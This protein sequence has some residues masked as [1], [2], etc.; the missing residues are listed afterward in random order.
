V[1]WV[2]LLIAFFAA[3]AIFGSL[4]TGK[5]LEPVRWRSPEIIWRDKNPR[6]FWISIFLAFGVFFFFLWGA[7]LA[8]SW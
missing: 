6:E 2:F 3:L 5:S 4:R 7:L 8:W 1:S